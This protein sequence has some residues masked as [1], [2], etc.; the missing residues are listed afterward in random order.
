MYYVAANI[1]VLERV[2]I[3]QQMANNPRYFVTLQQRDNMA[4]VI[5]IFK[6]RQTTTM[7]IMV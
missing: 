3:L 6:F 5:F 4:L 7:M 1:V 2:S